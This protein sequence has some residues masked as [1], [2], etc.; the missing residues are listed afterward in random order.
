MT[1][2]QFFADR[3]QLD[4]RQLVLADDIKPEVK[5]VIDGARTLDE[6]DTYL[7][8]HQISDRRN[9]ITRT[10]GQSDAVARDVVGLKQANPNCTHRHLVNGMS[11]I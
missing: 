6:V 10:A 5:S 1:I 3:K 7:D 4:R 2:L 11:S 9:E 8:A